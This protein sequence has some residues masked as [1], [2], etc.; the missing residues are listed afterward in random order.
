MPLQPVHLHHAPFSDLL[1]HTDVGRALYSQLVE[2]YPC[3][4][5]FAISVV[6]NQSRKVVSLANSRQPEAGFAKSGPYSAFS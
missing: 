4:V 3:L 1:N 6:M 5:F 2:W